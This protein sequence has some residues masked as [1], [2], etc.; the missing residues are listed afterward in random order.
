MRHGKEAATTKR[1][2]WPDET[3]EAPRTQRKQE[4][5]VLPRIFMEDTDKERNEILPEITHFAILLHSPAK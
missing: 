1:R 2:A 3:A 5:G 4:D